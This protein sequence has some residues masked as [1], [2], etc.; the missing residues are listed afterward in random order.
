MN[1]Q[2][3]LPEIFLFLW[4]IFIFIV[5]FFRKE[6]K[7]NLAYWALLG[8]IITIVLV[9]I[10]QKG[11]LFGGM[12]HA[13]SFSTFFNLI[14]LITGFL[15]IL[16]SVEFTKKLHSY[17]GEYF[18]LILFSMVGMM[19][20]ASAGELLTLYVSLEL[21][22]I[23]LF[24]LAAYRKD[25]Q[26]S[27]EAGLK[28]LILGGMSSAL[29]LFGISLLFGLTGTTFLKELKT[30]L[31]V[32][33]LSTGE[34]GPALMLSLIFIIAG[35]GFKLALVP[36]H[37]WVPDVYEGAPTPITAF[38][39][40]ASK[41]AGI[42]AFLRI[43]FRAFL[44][45]QVDW[46]LLLA[47]LAS[48]AMII[49]NIIA[50]LQTNIKRM[51]AYSSIA[52]IGYILIGAVSA[53]STGASSI[54]FYV[55]VYMFA[56]MGAFAAV[57]VFG[58]NTGSDEIRDYAGLSR[59]SPALA[60]MM[61]VFMLSLVGIPPLAGFMGKYYLFSSAIEQGYIWLVVVAILTSVISLYYYLGVVR[62]MYFQASPEDEKSVSIAITPALKT[63]L[64]ISVIGVLIFGI[65]PHIFLNLANQAAAVFLY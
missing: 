51:L 6:K 9:I 61:A 4:A 45:L 14:F 28:Y 27:S 62:Q 20:L 44:I 36:F 49:G 19:F 39:S 7:Q 33:F 48:L 29:L 22:T 12:F 13:D 52:Q 54:A 30:V 43:F 5:D 63:A 40:V 38:L 35:L 15:T 8:I 46:V 41:A 2:L 47:V 64:I 37:M 42:A 59:K 50:L 17:Q 31:I 11:D 65:L 10:S 58:N 60:A 21:T 24:I 26:K 23:P 25:E 32:K 53:S 56:N 55:F 3:L 1:Y 16:S 34:I 18:G 57:I